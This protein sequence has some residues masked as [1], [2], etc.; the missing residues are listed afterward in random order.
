[1]A[2]SLGR[3]CTETVLQG[4]PVE[5][6]LLWRWSALV[7]VSSDLL[8]A[9]FFLV[10]ARSIRRVELAPW[11][12]AWLA[13]LG[14]LSVVIV[15]WVLHPESRLAF[16]VLAGLYLFAKTMFLLWL[17]DGALQFVERRRLPQIKARTAGVVLILSM[18]CSALIPGIDALGIVG[19]SIIAAIMLG[20]VIL[21]ARRPAQSGNWLLMGFALRGALA[22]AEAIGFVVKLY[23]GDTAT[24]WLDAFLASHSSF[25]TGAEWVIAL[26]C[27]LTLYGTIQRELTRSNGKLMHA[28]EEM[29]NLLDHDQLTGVYNRRAMPQILHSARSTGA[30]ILFFD[31]DKFKHVNDQCG[32]HIGDACLT[33]FAKMLREYFPGDY[34]IRYAGDEFIVVTHNSEA[35]QVAGHIDSMRADLDKILVDGQRIEFSI[36][37]ARLFADGD[38]D[39]ALRAAD[40]AMYDEKARRVA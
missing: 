25:D 21:L 40:Q 3:A 24:D 28:K 27:V 18:A 35:A 10:L 34:V 20:G 6:L 14:A 39:A 26:G 13:N 5:L 32:H 16:V 9:V 4:H 36:G 33:L 2:P 37:S 38:A 30:T 15:F 22:L 1:M 12:N 19:S 23:T 8:I 11:V 7:Q 31:L 29:Q 17:V